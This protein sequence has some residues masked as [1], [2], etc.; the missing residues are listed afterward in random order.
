MA[1]NRR[2]PHLAGLVA[3]DL[4]TRWQFDAACQDV[5]DPDIFFP[6][7][8]DP[9][10]KAKAICASCPVTAKCLDYAL[11]AADGEDDHGI[12]G[13]LLPSERAALRARQTLLPD[14][15]LDDPAQAAAALELANRVGVA[16]AARAL[17][18]PRRALTV[19]WDRHGLSAAPTRSTRRAQTE[20]LRDDRDAAER[21]FELAGRLGVTRAAAALGVTHRSL[22][23]AWDQHG[24]GRPSQS[25][26]V[27]PTAA[28]RAPAADR[29][30]RARTAARDR[31][32]VPG[33]D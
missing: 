26:K 1:G 6:G 28:R 3:P 20:R 9:G 14:R 31:E 17:G 2:V 11:A 8:G 33:R 30:Q 18:V 32:E 24:L 10:T 7:K 4:D 5:A 15:G 12:Y 16:A 25:T 23:R 22:Y 19:A 27:R 13:G 21:A 29:A